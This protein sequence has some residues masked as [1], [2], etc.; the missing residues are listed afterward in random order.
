MTTDKQGLRKEIAKEIGLGE[1]SGVVEGLLK[2]FQD[3]GLECVGEEKSVKEIFPDSVAEPTSQFAMQVLAKDIY[4]KTKREIRYRILQST[5]S[6][7]AP[8]EVE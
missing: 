7:D 8:G 1:Q 2:I 6:S 4:N 3:F 5:R